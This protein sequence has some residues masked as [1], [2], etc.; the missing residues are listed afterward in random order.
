MNRSA[1][2]PA[3]TKVILLVVLWIL[4]AAASNA[5]VAKGPDPLLL[6]GDEITFDV[7]RKGERIGRHTVTF[8]KNTSGELTVTAKF[9]LKITLLAI[10]I[11]QFEYRSSALWLNGRLKR[12]EARVDDDGEKSAVR[13]FNNSKTMTILRRNGVLKWNGVLYPT[14]HWNVGVLCQKRV[15]NTLNGD[16]SRVQ[17]V[18]VGRERILAEG[19]WIEATRYRYSGDIDTTVWYDDSGRWVKMQ[20]PAKGG[21]TIDYQ[22]TRCGLGNA[23][24]TSAN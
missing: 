8:F 7:F 5:D 18:A 13:A 23:E 16:I 24:K 22:C 4:P 17:I 20:F 12:L 15:L 11:Y 6:Y 19:T 21:S 10:P 14:N 9:G 1:A 3:L 2:P